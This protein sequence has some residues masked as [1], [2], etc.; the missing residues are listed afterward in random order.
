MDGTSY[1]KYVSSCIYLTSSYN[2]RQVHHPQGRACKII[3]TEYKR[4][5]DEGN[6]M[7]LVS[8]E[9]RCEIGHGRGI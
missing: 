6:V 4:K 2:I 8:F 3:G 5:S 9:N 1:G 7:H